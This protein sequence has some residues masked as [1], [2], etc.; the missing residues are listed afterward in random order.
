[1][2]PQA[3][4]V[5][6]LEA[7]LARIQTNRQLAR[8]ASG[9]A[10]A[11]SIEAAV[12]R[13]SLSSPPAPIAAPKPASIAPP[14]PKPASIAPPAQE[15]AQIS[16]QEAAQKPAP[17]MPAA[18]EP[19]REVAEPMP[20]KALS[21]PPPAAEELPT[22]DALTPAAP[23]PEPPAL[24]AMPAAPAHE[25]EPELPA[26]IESRELQTSGPIAISEGKLEPARPESFEALIEASLTLRLRA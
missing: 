13:S 12:Q 9:A 22:L 7:L 3:E 25:P 18:H 21:T 24:E 10:A 20:L 6:K 2:S 5:E 17:Q 11:S 16:A 15:S 14:A 1:M 4:Q 26:A 23:A 8:E 19:I